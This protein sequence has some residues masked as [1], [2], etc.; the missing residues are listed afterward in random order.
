MTSTLFKKM[1][2]KRFFLVGMLLSVSLFSFGQSIRVTGSVSDEDG[3]PLIGVTIVVRGT[4]LGTTSDFNGEF[5]LTV[6]SDTAVLQ[7]RYV[8]YQSQDITVGSRR[9]LPVVMKEMTE[10][11]GEL[12]VVAFGKQKKESVIG[13]ITTINTADLKV[14]S[15]NL[16]TS[17][18]GK[19]AGVI[20]YQRSG[21]PGA[22]NAEFFV[23]GVTTFGYKKDPLI[24][25]DNNESSTDDLARLAPDDIASFSIM[26]DATATALYGSRGANGVI[27][28]STKSGV[29]GPAKINVR[30]E[31]AISTPTRLMKFADGIT[32]MNLHNEAMR[33]RY[34]LLKEPYDQSKIDNTVAGVNPYVYPNTDWYKSLFNDIAR[35]E[36]LNFS[37]SGGG[38]VARYYLAGHV[39][40]DG[41]V[42]KVDKKNNFNNNVDLSR[43]ML[44]SNVNINITKT[45]EVIARMSGAFDDY[46]GPIDGGS[47]VYEKVLQTNPVLF[48]AYYPADRAHEHTKHILYGNAGTVTEKDGSPV[49]QY[50]NPY[51]D[52]TKGYKDETTSQ[53]SVQFELKQDLN[54]LLKG[55]SLRGMFNTSRFSHYKVSRFYGPYYYN[56]GSYD[57]LN[58]VYTLNRLNPDNIG[59]EELRFKEGN[60]D[61][62]KQNYSTTYFETGAN[63][64][65][66]FNDKHEV[67][68]LLV[69]TMRNE[70]KENTQDLQKSLSYRNMGLAG[71][72]TYAYDSRYLFEAN[73]G[74]NGSERFS[75]KERFGLFPSAG[76]GWIVSNEHFYGE[77]LKKTLSNLKLKATYGLVGN[78]AIGDA[79]DRFFYLS[80]VN[81]NNSDKASGFGTLGNNSINGVSISRYANDLITW[82]TAKKLNVSSE[83]GLW[84]KLDI[85]LEWFREH[86]TNILQTRS[87]IPTTMG[88]QTAIKAN[89]G[90]AKSRGVDMSF[91]YNHSINKDLWITGMANFTYATSEYVVYEEP[92]YPDAPWKSRVGYS[93]KQHYG[94]I[95]ERLFID[96]EEVNNSPDQ[97]GWYEAGDIKYKDLNKDGKID[98]LDI[99]P[100]GYP[101]TPEIVYGF[102]LSTGYKFLDVSFFFQ[103][104]ARSSFFISYEKTAP[105]LNGQNA[106]LQAYADD[107]WSETNRDIYAVWPRLSTEIIQ[108]NNRSST[109]FLRDGSFLRLKSVECGYSLPEKMMSK[110]HLSNVRIYFTGT[111]LLTFSKF[112]MWDPEMG[113]EGWKY[114]IQK[115]FNFGLQVSF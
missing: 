40:K 106:L 102:G 61:P 89:V 108:N 81:M 115:V 63:W 48:P 78:D 27:L 92:E 83:I 77:E 11:L 71:R 95:A 110:V 84:N 103:G 72:A 35:S 8:G 6:P 39:I 76:I 107:H 31:E 93:I 90:E 52:M 17:F 3:G 23:R 21:E 43:Y 26:K 101:E 66:T 88:L 10:E 104:S 45:T 12:T 19:M 13:S 32:Y 97:F 46:K 28:I 65:D 111:N 7:C 20:A 56:I 82:E 51:A 109:W 74:Y 85:Q 60:D 68:G 112:K 57:K 22:D 59:F 38:K 42:L 34:P 50:T 96:D 69:F 62:N 37:M 24:L 114:P 9:I 70:L 16:T 67:G 64:S 14:P 113:A 75:K 36:R 86:R 4:S 25:I 87:S 80:N 55:L 53:I 44:R 5:S 79:N 73:F 105:F 41:G 100:I 91:N 49:P 99:A 18:A 2:G 33:T 15:S 1:R 47:G 30:F 94:Y 29:E 98:E 54:F 58:D